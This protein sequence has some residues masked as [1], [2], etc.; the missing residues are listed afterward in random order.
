MK[1]AFIVNEFPSVSQTFVLNQIIGLIDRGHDVG[2][3]A[4]GVRSNIKIHED[5]RKY[6]LLEHTSYPLVRPQNVVRRIFNSLSFIF[7][8]IK[9]NPKAIFNSLNI[10]K[11]GRKAS[12]LTLLYQIIP[13]LQT[14]NHQDH[15]NIEI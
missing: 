10:F 4:E 2:I 15:N 14:C 1:I 13:F 6:N 12:S 7:K 5:V 3:F 9:K 11:Y 8:L